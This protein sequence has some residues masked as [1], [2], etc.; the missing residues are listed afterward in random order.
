MLLEGKVSYV[1]SGLRQMATKHQLKGK[2]KKTIKQVTGYFYYN[3][4]RMRYDE[5]LAKG[6][7]IGSGAAEG[8]GRHLVKD[9]LCRT[10]MRWTMEGAQ[11]MLDLRS[12]YISGH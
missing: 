2:Q 1:I 7:P 6:Y 11:A 12:V 5:Y 3:R 4:S 8:S 10:G 9:R